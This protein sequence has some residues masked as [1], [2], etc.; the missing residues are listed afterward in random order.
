[1][2]AEN[3]ERAIRAGVVIGDDR[4]HLLADVTESVGKDQRLV[5][6]ARDPDQQVI[7]IQQCGVAGDNA[8]AVAQ[9]PDAGWWDDHDRASVVMLFDHQPVWRP[10]AESVMNSRRFSDRIA[11]M[12]QQA[13]TAGRIPNWQR[14]VSLHYGVMESMSCVQVSPLLIR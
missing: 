6:Q 8:F 10:A 2:G 3:V 9:L 14:S 13:G 7:L 1:M 5:A 12:P 11:A 4:V